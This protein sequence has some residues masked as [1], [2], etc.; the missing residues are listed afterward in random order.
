MIQPGR[1]VWVARL[2]RAWLGPDQPLAGHWI[3]CGTDCVW[4]SFPDKAGGWEER[5]VTRAF[6]RSMIL[7]TGLES[8]EI[9]ER[10]GGTRPTGR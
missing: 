10:C 2:Y 1:D 5:V 9:L 4:Y 7:L 6:G 3:A 8:T